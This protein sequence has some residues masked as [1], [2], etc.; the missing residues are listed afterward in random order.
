MSLLRLPPVAMP[1][2]RSAATAIESSA[3]DAASALTKDVYG[4]AARS[5]RR[6]LR[7][8]VEVGYWPSSEVPPDALTAAYGGGPDSARKSLVRHY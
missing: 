6:P 1:K 4:M 8:C 5:L 7:P 2:G 3:H